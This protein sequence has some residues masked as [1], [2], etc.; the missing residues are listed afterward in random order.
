MGW[1][2]KNFNKKAE[3]LFRITGTMFVLR[4]P[5][6]AD[7]EYSSKVNIGLN[8]KVRTTLFFLKFG[9]SSVLKVDF[10]F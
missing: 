8:L 10:I 5:R 7:Q 6:E 9:N 2:R 4:G 3:T 1:F